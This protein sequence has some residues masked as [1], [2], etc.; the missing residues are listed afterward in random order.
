MSEAATLD[1]LTPEHRPYEPFGSAREAMKAKEPEV[2]L[3]GAAGTGKSRAVLEKLHLLAERCPGMRGLI[4]RKT[5]AS[6]TES[7]LVTFEQL[8][9]PANHPV[10]A[11]DCSRRMRQSYH[12]PNG[13]EIAVCGM[14]NPG[15]IHSSEWDIIYCQESI[16]I[17]EED[18]E[19]LTVRNRNL[20]GTPATPYRQVIGDTNP[21]A[22]THWLKKRQ[23]T[24]KLRMIECRHEDNPMLWDRKAKAWTPAG[25]EYLAK[26]DNLTGARRDRLRFGKWVSAEGLVY[27]DWNAAVHIIDRFPVPI[28]WPRYWSID[29]GFTNPF[30]WQLWAMDGDGRLYLLRQIYFTQRPV[31][32]HAKRIIELAR[33]EMNL[34]P[35]F[36]LAKVLPRAI[37]ADPEDANGRATLERYLQMRVQPARKVNGFTDGIQAVASRLRPAGDGKPRLFIMRDSLDQKDPKLGHKPCCL[38]EEMD[39]YIWQPQPAMSRAEKNIPDRPIDKDN[40]G[41]DALRYLCLYLDDTPHYRV[42]DPNKLLGPTD[43]PPRGPRSMD[44]DDPELYRV[45]DQEDS[46][47]RAERGYRR[48]M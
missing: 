39:S 21:G 24:G 47:R 15:K 11:S 36:P 23:G 1:D 26:L 5:R 42:P 20:T 22:P 12:Y 9:L 40:H 29:F 2:C 4:V 10:L 37:I 27:E 7:A 34:P 19:V 43:Q 13:S 28:S 35:D 8:V 16:E 48:R 6:L 30:T 45:L 41:E 18:W 17:T 25:D 32:D 3:S 14:D 44:Q 33:E 46:G 38:E 31:E